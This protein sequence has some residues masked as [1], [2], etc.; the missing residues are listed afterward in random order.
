M[1]GSPKSSPCSMSYRR[2]TALVIWAG[3]KDDFDPVILSESYKDSHPLL[4]LMLHGK[5]FYSH[6]CEGSAHQY[7]MKS[8]TCTCHTEQLT[9]QLTETQ[10]WLDQNSP[11]QNAIKCVVIIVAFTTNFN[12]NKR[13]P[14][15]MLI[16][17]M[18]VPL[19]SSLG[20]SGPILPSPQI[21]Y[22]W[23]VLSM[24]PPDPYM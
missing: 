2:P 1:W 10:F 22:W 16:L 6:V 21:S 5:G 12:L 15:Y 20:P 7:H 11:C 23:L 9:E 24:P 14:I 4:L 17:L 18:S 8:V 19:P 13:L 3:I